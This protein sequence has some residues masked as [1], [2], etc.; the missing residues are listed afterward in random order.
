MYW[1]EQTNVFT[2]QCIGLWKRWYW[3]VEENKKK[4]LWKGTMLIAYGL[5]SH[6]QIACG[7]FSFSIAKAT[8]EDASN[9]SMSS[10]TKCR[11]SSYSTKSRAIG[12]QRG[13]TSS[14]FRWSNMTSSCLF[15]RGRNFSQTSQIKFSSQHFRKSELFSFNQYADRTIRIEKN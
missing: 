13:T 5:I 9:P 11:K 7:F 2:N 14:S 4:K 3:F 6:S 10:E 1:F 8:Y 12:L 15:N